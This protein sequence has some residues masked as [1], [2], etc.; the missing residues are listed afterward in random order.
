[1]SQVKVFDKLWAAREDILSTQDFLI[2]AKALL[3]CTL[4]Y[5]RTKHHQLKRVARLGKQARVEV[6]FTSMGDPGLPYGAD[7]AVF[8]WIQTQAYQT[9]VVEFSRLR[10]FFDAFRLRD[11]GASY[12]RFYQRVQRLEDLAIKIELYD[13]EDRTRGSY[14]PIKFSRTPRTA[15][16]AQELLQHEADGQLLMIRSRYGFALDR[17]FWEYL[18]E[19]P[20]PMP[21]P[22]M[23]LF[24]NEPKAWDFC[25]FVLYRCYAA[26]QQSIVPWEALRQQL[27][28]SDRNHRQLQ[29]TLRRVLSRMK[30]IY[31]QLPA[32]FQP[33]YG[34]LRVAPWRPPSA[35]DMRSL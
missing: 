24:H 17:D 15:R 19:H 1:M 26:R 21:L 12:R 5:R 18:R 35:D 22:L 34:G 10:D 31:P 11:D 4:P 6:T 27:S 25:Q 29:W 33:D 28:S 20:V 23:R 16:K 9:G 3:L 30:V 2:Q 32:T 7:R 13:A 14:L 8:A